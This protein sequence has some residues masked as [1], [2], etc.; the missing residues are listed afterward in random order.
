VTTPAL[1]LK[2]GALVFP[3]FE[4]LDVFGPLNGLA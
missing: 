4:L 1:P 2:V 3:G